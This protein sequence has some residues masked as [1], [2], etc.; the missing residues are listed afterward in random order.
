MLSILAASMLMMTSVPAHA[1]TVETGVTDWAKLPKVKKKARAL[2]L[3]PLI[4]F[5]Q[6][7]LESGECKVPGMRPDR[8]DLDIPYAVLVEPDGAV[9]RIVIGETGCPGLNTLIGST[10]YNW[11]QQGDFRP[12][13]ESEALWYGGRVAFAHE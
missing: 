8:F 4:D 1:P 10:V 12:T 6:K 2:E 3:S 11:V 13:G 7:V 9:K 5:A